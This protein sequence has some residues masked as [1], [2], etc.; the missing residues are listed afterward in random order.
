VLAVSLLA[1][2]EVVCSLRICSIS[3]CPLLAI[4][5][6]NTN[7]PTTTTNTSHFSFIKGEAFFVGIVFSSCITP[8]SLSFSFTSSGW[9]LACDSC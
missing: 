6:Q 4:H 7:T 8:M 1:T 9:S 2:L 3:G 5:H